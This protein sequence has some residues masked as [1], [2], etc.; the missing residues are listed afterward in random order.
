MGMLISVIGFQPMFDRWNKSERGILEELK[1]KA[2][3]VSSVHSK[4]NFLK[5][6]FIVGLAVL[7]GFLAKWTAQFFPAIKDIVSSYTWVII[8]VSL[9][10]IVASMTPLKNLEKFGSTRMGYFFLYFVLTSIGAKAS[11]KFESSTFILIA[12]GFLW[13]LIHGAVLVIV[14]RWIKAP[15]FLVAVASQ[16]NVGGVASAPIVAEVYQ[17]GLASIGLLLAI[18]GNVIGT[19]IGIITGQICYWMST[20]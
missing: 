18:L 2:V 12:L 3:D 16:A 19:Y 1:T 13:V 9:L 4:L 7:V 14:A 8:I 15:M 10:G 5:I 11:L 17:P 20:Y 6:F